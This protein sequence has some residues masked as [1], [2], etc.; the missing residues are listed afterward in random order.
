MG[1][2]MLPAAD[3][4]STLRAFRAAQEQRVRSYR[5]LD[6][7]FAAYLQCKQEAPYRSH[8][9]L[10]LLRSGIMGSAAA[11]RGLA[12]CT[13]YFC[14]LGKRWRIVPGSLSTE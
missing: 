1:R 4:L 2:S 8:A 10:T 7:G 13:A 6:E 9:A 14:S 12:G 3:V 5:R 11:K